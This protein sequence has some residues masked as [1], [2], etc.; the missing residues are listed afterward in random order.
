MIKLID[1]AQMK[2]AE[3]D[4]IKA[5]AMEPADLMETAARA[6]VGIFCGLVPEKTTAILVLCGTGNNG[7]DGLAIARLLQYAGYSDIEAHIVPTSRPGT[8]E[9]GINLR[10]LSNTPV[11]V[12][13]LGDVKAFSP[14]QPVLIDAL[15]GSG[16]N[17]PLNAEM[18]AL[19]AKIN[20]LGRRVIAVDCP[21][22][23]RC[24]GPLNSGEPV[25]RASDVICFQ[26]PKLN[27]FYPESANA[28]DRFHVVDIGLREEFMES[29][30]SHIHLIDQRDINRLIKARPEFSHKGSFGHALIYAG[31]KGK[32]GAALLA[33]EACVYSGAG[34][35]SV[36]L[37]EEERLALHIR[38][39]EA[40]FV[41]LEAQG[42]SGKGRFSAIAIGP[43]LDGNTAF[44]EP[45]LE[46]E[47][48]PLVIDADGLNF[49]ARSP[50]KLNK[51]PAG[52]ILTP[53]LKEFDRLF[54]DS[55]SWFDRVELARSEAQKRR[56][57]I[58]LKNRYT[59]LVLPDGRV[60]I[61]PTGNPGMASG[62]MGDVLTGILVSFLAQSYQA[63]EACIIA[64]FVHGKAGD[65]V[66]FEGNAVVTASSLIK[67]LP[68]VL[69]ELQSS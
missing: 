44:I 41:D 59:F 36:A 47:A 54:G 32:V 39:P 23:F 12:K 26:R 65:L 58:I 6:F 11:V 19:V 43:G 46:S 9:F 40:M 25:L 31:S 14:S 64:C 4:F 49:L 57:Y 27:F 22:G 60:L 55:Q 66:R 35:T 67:K 13:H 62:G 48:A 38:L 52:S 2:C 61:N 45:M 51:L 50:E 15:L 20:G 7:G 17:R 16:L 21:T 3:Q 28:F 10:R 29:F 42:N 33:A 56:I 53:H 24:D 63:E 18:A 69:G 34:L 37:P 1:A 8:E 5:R 68:Q 30:S